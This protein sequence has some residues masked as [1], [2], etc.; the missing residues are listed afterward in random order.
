MKKNKGNI[1]WNFFASVKL[2]LFSL[3]I[4]AAA[5]IIGTLIPQNES[6]EKYIELYGNGTA[7]VFK[8][9]SF[10]DMYASWW[11]VGMLVLFS[12]NLIVC[13]IERLPHIWKVV[14]LDNL[15]N[16]KIDRLRKMAVRKAYSVQSTPAQAKDVIQNI[17]KT[18]GWKTQSGEKDGGTLLFSQKGAWTRLGV[19]VVH[20]SIL[21]IFAGAL[22]GTF[23]GFKASVMVPEGYTTDK[24]Y[25]SEKDHAP[26]PLK[27]FK[28]RCNQ[29]DL[30]YYDTGMPK[31]Y[32]SSLTVIR[33][34][35]TSFTQSIEVNHPLQYA[36]LTFYQA[37]YQSMDGQFVARIINDSNQNSGDFI[38]EPR[39]EQKWPPENI[40]FGITNITG[41]DNL[42]RYSYKIWFSD[43]KAA[44]SEFWATEGGVVTV[45]RPDTTYS[46]TVKPRF[47]TG[48][49]VVKD[50]GVWTVYF[51]CIMMIVGL[52][53]IFYLSHRRIWVFVSKDADSNNST[54]LV[55]GLSNKNKIGF[56]R[57][58]AA[59]Y[60]EIESNSLLEFKNS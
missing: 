46:F 32:V 58:M 27:G 30:T 26:I 3:F 50:P 23:L 15:S 37:S 9:L 54:I 13:T 7:K 1:V 31:D 55:A 14:T 8:M 22:I 36:G 6:P 41:P 44:P 49:Q 2:A 34:D 42:R 33:D 5:S 43:G 45:K 38:I 18:A 40:S 60:E 17:M 20:V 56:E 16:T 39:R 52:I 29:F 59:L 57:T 21:V 12:L 28:V 48:L 10:D 51:G 24:V 53:I 11:F 35:N 19:I 25:S 47:A 4:L